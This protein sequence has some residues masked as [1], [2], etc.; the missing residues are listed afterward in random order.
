MRLLPILAEGRRAREALEALERRPGRDSGA[1]HR[2]GTLRGNILIERY[3]ES[4]D[5][6]RNPGNPRD[7]ER[8]EE[9]MRARKGAA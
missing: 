8:E 5:W 3:Y 7:R 4:A 6:L 2:E 9:W 1:P